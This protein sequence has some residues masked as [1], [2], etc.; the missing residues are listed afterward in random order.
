MSSFLPQA[1]LS[2]LC[3]LQF[4]QWTATAQHTGFCLPPWVRCQ[5]Q[6]ALGLLLLL[7]LP[8]QS[9]GPKLVSPS[10]P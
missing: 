1:C 6:Q 8:L 4:L 2:V 5:A 10:L 9:L 3:S 7:L